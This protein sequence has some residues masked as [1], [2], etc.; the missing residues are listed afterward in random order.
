MS[1]IKATHYTY[2]PKTRTINW[3]TLRLLKVRNQGGF[4]KNIAVYMV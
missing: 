4:D 1:F 2:M 3:F